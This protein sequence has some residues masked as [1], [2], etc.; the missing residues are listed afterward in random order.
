MEEMSDTSSD[1]LE[2]FSEGS[3][4]NVIDALNSQV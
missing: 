1:F 2:L 4:E 3:S